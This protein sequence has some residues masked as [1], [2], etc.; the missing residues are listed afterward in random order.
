MHLIRSCILFP[1]RLSKTPEEAQSALLSDE[2]QEKLERTVESYDDERRKIT[3]VLEN[4]PQTDTCA[5]LTEQLGQLESELIRTKT[6]L[7]QTGKKLQDVNTSYAAL[8]SLISESAALEKERLELEQ[9]AAPYKM[10][11]NDLSGRNPKNIPFNSWALGIYFERIVEYANSRFFSISGGRF[12]FKL[13]SDRNQ[14]G[15][16]KGLDLVVS[17]TFTGTDR[18]TAT[19]SG[20][21]TF[22]A[23]ISLALAL[24]DIV[25]SRNG[26]VHLDSLFIDEGF[27][28]LDEETLDCAVTVLNNLQETKKVGIISHVESMKTA[29]PS[30]IEIIKTAEG[31]HITVH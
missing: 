16:F 27:G 4:A 8:Q 30:Q 15:G 5:S 2:V 14:G 1:Q 21:E 6:E 10:L 25:Q 26:G 28:S 22:M 24:T 17:D 12:L 11:F 20:G 13:A 9:K 7:E 3:A 23:S 18:D 29:I 31:S 19:L